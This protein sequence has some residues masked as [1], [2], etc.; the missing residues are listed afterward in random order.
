MR[1]Q[2]WEYWETANDAETAISEA[3]DGGTEGDKEAF[4]NKEN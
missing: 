3:S 4:K 1:E 2:Q